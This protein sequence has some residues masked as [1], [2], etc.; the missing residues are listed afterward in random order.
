MIK[1]GNNKDWRTIALKAKQ[2]KK[3]PQKIL[4]IIILGQ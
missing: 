2:K 3:Q 4:D 1:H